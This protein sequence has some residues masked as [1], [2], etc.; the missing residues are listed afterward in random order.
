MKIPSKWTFNS[1]DV[2]DNFDSHVREQLPW[3]DIVSNAIAHIGNHYIPDNGTV[4]DI[5]ASTGNI[6]H[7]LSDVLDQR[8][9]RFIPVEKSPEMAK[10]YTGK[11]DVVEADATEIQF[12]DFDFGVFFLMFS[13]FPLQGVGVL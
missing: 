13:G 7:V 11:H 5:G 2:A 3:Y 9:V 1:N 10:K 4:Y 12:E 6:E 8:N